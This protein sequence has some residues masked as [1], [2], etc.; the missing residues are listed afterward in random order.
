M[1]DFLKELAHKC[2]AKYGDRCDQL[3]VIF[4]NKRAG[5]YFAKHLANQHKKPIWSPMIFSLEEY[6][7]NSQSK[8]LVDDLQL[9]FVLY[10][11]YI[12]LVKH[13][14]SFESFYPWGEMIL[15]DFNDIDNYLLDAAHV[16][17]VIKSQKELDES[18]AFLSE[19]EQKVIQQFWSGFLPTPNKKQHE[20]IQTWEV[21]GPLYE[22]FNAQLNKNGWVYKGRMIKEFSEREA[23]GGDVWFAGFNAL[24]SAEETIM[25]SYLSVSTNAV[26]WDLDEYYLS[27]ENQEA[28]MF[29]RGYAKDSAFRDSIS[30][31]AV[32]QLSDPSKNINVTASAMGMGQIHAATQIVD[33]WLK[34]GV[35]EN[36]IL[37]VLADESLVGNL[38]EKLDSL[39]LVVNVT[40]GWPLNRTRAST[41]ID[42]LL[43]LSTSD[44]GSTSF[45]KLERLFQYSDWLEMD[46]LTVSQIRE[47]AIEQNAVFVSVEQMLTWVPSIR[48]VV[49]ASGSVLDLIKALM[50]MIKKLT[51]TVRSTTDK[52]AFESL[53]GVLKHIHYAITRT[54]IDLSLDTFEKLFRKIA[55]GTKLSLA[56]DPFDG[57]QVLGILETRNLCFDYVVVIGMNEGN[58]PSERNANSFI[59]YNI[60]RAFELPVADHNDA[61]QAY[62]FYRLLQSAKHVELLYN[63]ISEFNRNGELSRYV[64][65]L[66]L[67]SNLSMV[68]RQAISSVNLQTPNAI[69]ISKDAVVME[70][71]KDYCAGTGNKRLTPSAINSYIECPLRFYFRYVEQLYE[72]EQ[73]YEDIDAAMLGNLL[74]HSMEYLYT[75]LNLVAIKELEE[76]Y[77][78]VDAAVIYAFEQLGMSVNNPGV[79]IIG[80]QQIAYEVVKKYSEQILSYDRTC[81]PFE[82]VG[83]ERKDYYVDIALPEGT[84]QL[85]V[86]LRGVI[87]RVDKKDGATRILDYKTGRDSREYGGIDSL[88]DPLDDKRNK[89][90]FQLFY[91]CLLYAENHQEE[92]GVIVP[93]LYNSAD[94]F[95]EDF[96]TAITEHIKGRKPAKMIVHNAKDHLDPYRARLSTLLAELF[97]PAVD[98]IQTE[99]EDKCNYCPYAGICFKN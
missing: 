92:A 54:Q 46:Q 18:F 87:D 96:G 57:M 2:H 69:V 23:I 77:S 64:R 17:R 14:E 85:S 24:T 75:G 90:V 33:Q 91:Y 73:L 86:G 71:L 38:M 21:L 47:D 8:M 41:F 29:L 49:E 55:Q 72:P 43:F 1:A 99:D 26:F 44:S 16:F 35:D 11:E 78:K 25:K 62:L 4:P 66:E 13:A 59:P 3:T 37:V 95:S 10:Q 74:H 51:T 81:L 45:N 94:L 9:I 83:L 28:G 6:I 60:R 61:I 20:F 7:T 79:Q 48:E 19:K 76:A 5:M 97:D 53:Y 40:M 58:W 12:K 80:R 39:G 34:E 32:A 22:A 89:A 36:Q 56:G 31:D 42:Q 68:F 52:M 98:F 70:R 27:D 84:E 30:R 88:F 93:G 63:N 65:Q 82:I 15:K 67:E 50:Q